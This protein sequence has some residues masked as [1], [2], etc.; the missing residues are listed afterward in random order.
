[1]ESVAFIFMFKI[2]II[3]DDRHMRTACSRALS[4]EGWSVLG[5]ESGDEG[6]SI[7]RSST[8]KI[9]VVLLDQLMPGM[10]GMDVLAEIKAMDPNLPVIIITGSVTAETATGIIREGAWGCLPKPFIPEELRTIVR[11]ACEARPG[12]VGVPPA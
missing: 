5:A 8:E 10:S 11:K 7:L 4:K 6:L 3:D 2:L 1:V 12:S 9:D